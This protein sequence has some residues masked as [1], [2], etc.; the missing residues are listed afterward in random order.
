MERFKLVEYN[1]KEQ[2]IYMPNEIFDDIQNNLPTTHAAFAYSYYFLIS[3]LYRYAKYSSHK[4]TQPELKQFLRYSLTNTKIDFIIKRGGVLDAIGYTTTTNDYPVT[5]TLHD[6]ELSF[7]YLSDLKKS[8]IYSENDKNYR[9]K[10][11]IKAFYRQKE[12]ENIGYNNGTF[13]EID[14]THRLSI[15]S[16][17]NAMENTEVGTMGFYI[18]AFLKERSDKFKDGVY[19]S[20]QQITEKLN[21]SPATVSKYIKILE[22]NRYISVKRSHFMSGSANKYIVRN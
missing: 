5:W 7:T 6:R 12:A 2:Y 14:N 8:G 18:Y 4:F 19:V 16:F 11:P 1:D 9:I 17:I 3:Y 15:R 10:L 13:F 21:L 20:N 22:E